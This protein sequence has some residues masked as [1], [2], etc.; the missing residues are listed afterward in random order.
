MAGQRFSRLASTFLGSLAGY[1]IERAAEC[2]RPLLRSVSKPVRQL[3]GFSLGA[4][5]RPS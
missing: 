5:P 3:A 2:E 1:A 4:R